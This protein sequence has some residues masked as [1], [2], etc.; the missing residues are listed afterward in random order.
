V[1]TFES[2]GSSRGQAIENA[3][4][5]DYSLSF[6]DSV[7]V[8][9]EDLRFK[10]NAIFRGQH[11]NMILY[12]P[13]DF[14]FTMDEGMS[15]FISQYVD[16]EFLEG[17]TWKMTRNG[18]ECINCNTSRTEAISDL[19]DFN[20]LEITGRF[21]VRILQGDNYSVE[22]NGPEHE[23]NRYSVHRAGETL[24]IDYENH[25]NMDWEDWDAKRFSMEEM[26]IRITM[27][28]VEK[29]E[30]TGLGNIRFDDLN[31]HD[32][33]IETR[34]PVK[35]SGDLNVQN[36][37]IRLTGKSEAD[38]SGNAH[39]LDAR[40]EFASRLRAYSLQTQDAVVEVA[41]AS[42]AK[43]NVTGTLEMD[44]GVASDIDYRGNPKVVRQ[45]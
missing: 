11:L 34:G 4:M 19:R 31:G 14:P 40:V 21:D 37:M 10:S 17:Y 22:L 33:V 13:Y 42:S 2:Q 8:F 39:N 36:L 3:K 12:I 38:L 27:P 29:I 32:L 1:Q 30:A 41:G 7:F 24:V 43:V 16:G 6:A 44:E 25:Q 9:D 5:V 45:D 20:V 18:L 28:A 15:R 26:E 35:V 23:K